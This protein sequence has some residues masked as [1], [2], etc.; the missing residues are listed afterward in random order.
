MELAVGAYRRVT[1][2]V[3]RGAGFVVDLN[4]VV[5]CL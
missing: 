2:A 3:L 4:M 5:S 1:G